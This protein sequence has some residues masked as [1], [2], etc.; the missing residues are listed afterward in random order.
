MINIQSTIKKKF[1][2]NYSWIQFVNNNNNNDD[3]DDNDNKSKSFNGN[4][5]MRGEWRK[6]TEREWEKGKMGE[7]KRKKKNFYTNYILNK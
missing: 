4:V 1:S 6:K 3:K 5:I 7:K 2:Q